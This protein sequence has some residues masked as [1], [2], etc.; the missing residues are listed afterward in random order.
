M[1]WF[2]IDYGTTYGG[3][4]C[5]SWLKSHKKLNCVPG[6]QSVNDPKEDYNETEKM[7]IDNGCI[8]FN[9]IISISV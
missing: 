2:N 8:K 6:I 5:V 4:Y 7:Y 3:P 1:L 9:Y